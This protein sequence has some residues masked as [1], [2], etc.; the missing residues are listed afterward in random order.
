MGIL[1]RYNSNLSIFSKI[2]VYS[3]IIIEGFILSFIDSFMKTLINS[4]IIGFGAIAVDD[5]LFLQNFPQFNTKVEVKKRMRYA[6]GLAGTALVAASRLGVKAA[7]YG[8]LGEDELSEFTI[9]EFTKEKVDTSLC[10]KKEGAKPIH[11]TIIIDQ[12]SGG[13]TILFSLDGFQSPEIDEITFDSLRSSKIIFLDSYVL[14]IFPRVLNLA[15]STGIPI[16]ADIESDRIRDFPEILMAIDH[17]IL[18]IDVAALIVNK[19]SPE[20]ILM[21]LDSEKRICSVITDGTNGCWYKEKDKPIFH[22]PAFHVKTVDTTGCGDVFHGA[23]AAALIRG[24]N[25]LTAV[26]QASAAAAI[27]AT[28]PGGRN[29]IPYLE[30][31]LVFCHQNKHIHPRE[32]NE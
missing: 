20:G 12:S 18:N 28:Q 6:G 10:I 32:I 22:M 30:N 2:D 7:Y 26:L 5:L 21:A 11:S 1:T 15:H 19:K 29:G 27:K 9:N 16:I 8:I 23:Y 4:D 13:R 14:G 3:F 25:I 17:L 31:L 24:K